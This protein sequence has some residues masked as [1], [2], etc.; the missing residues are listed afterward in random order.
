MA[1]VF[2][3]REKTVDY[4]GQVRKFI[5][6]S[7]EEL[8]RLEEEIDRIRE[9]VARLERFLQGRD[10]GERGRLFSDPLSKEEAPLPSSRSYVPSPEGPLPQAPSPHSP[11]SGRLP[12]PSLPDPAPA[13]AFL[14]DDAGGTGER[15]RAFRP[16]GEVAEEILQGH[17]EG[18][19]LDELYLAMKDLAEI[20][21]SRDLKNA[22][23][24]ALIRRRPQVVSPRRG[25]FRWEEKE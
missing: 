24:V 8:G 10:A 17:S 23:R 19:S 16:V 21:P 13:E 18:M 4:A 6:E 2:V 11:S 14:R 1:Y 12:F 7:K 9:V 25:W 15:K 3:G 22:I 5:A 20:A